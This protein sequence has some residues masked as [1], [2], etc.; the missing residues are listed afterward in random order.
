[1]VGYSSGQWEA[2]WA[3]VS[4]VATVFVAFVAA[5]VAVVEVRRYSTLDAQRKAADAAAAA[6]RAS[7]ER[8]KRQDRH[9]AAIERASAL[10]VEKNE[11][12]GKILVK[13]TGGFQFTD[14]TV[15]RWDYGELEYHPEYGE[16]RQIEAIDSVHVGTVQPNT[17]VVVAVPRYWQ[18]LYTDVVGYQFEFEDDT[19]PRIIHDPTDEPNASETTP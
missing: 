10:R 9:V 1:M 8:A 15:H 12:F 13:N 18:I 19:A 14:V 17:V 16:I 7:E 4:A 6:S 3:G 2:W 5:W 11:G